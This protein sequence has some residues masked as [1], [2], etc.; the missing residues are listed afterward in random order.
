MSL[1]SN[2]T[3]WKSMINK[4]QSKLQLSAIPFSA[5]GAV[6]SLSSYFLLGFVDSVVHGDL[7]SHG[8]VFSYEWAGNYWNITG[9]I[10]TSFLIT[11][12]L[13][14]ISLIIAIIILRNS[15][16]EIKYLNCAIMI[17]VI[18][19]L[20][21]SLFLF[22]QIDGIVNNTLYNFGLQFSYQW[23]DQYSNYLIIIES[24]LLLAISSNLISFLSC[25]FAKPRTQIS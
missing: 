13:I 2:N 22:I 23:F 15:G 9:L 18:A 4:T 11:G 20:S 1:E 8:L 21:Y 16:M 3:L 5:L 10:R 24:L 19:F 6:L 12:I 7:Y 17:S 14:A 25:L